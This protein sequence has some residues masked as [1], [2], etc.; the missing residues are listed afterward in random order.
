M[1]VTHHD[2]LYPMEAIASIV[3]YLVYQSVG[4]SARGRR[5]QSR[6]IE[7]W[8]LQSI[9]ANPCDTVRRVDAIA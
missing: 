9:A 7:F 2:P 3:R 4:R 6:R 8:C 5:Q 1:G